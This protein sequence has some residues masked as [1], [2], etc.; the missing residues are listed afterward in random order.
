MMGQGGVVFFDLPDGGKYAHCDVLLLKSSSLEV[1][2]F[3]LICRVV[4]GRDVSCLPLSGVLIFRLW[5]CVFF[6]LR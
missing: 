5:P 1:V 4:A 2:F 3:V 6:M